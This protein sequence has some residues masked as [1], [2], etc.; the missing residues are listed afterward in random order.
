M[1]TTVDFMEYLSDQLG[2][3]TYRKMF[4]EYGIYRD[5]KLFA[6][7]CDNQLFVK[8]TEGGRPFG[9]SEA[10]PYEGAKP[11]FL[12]DDLEDRD[13]L[14]ALVKITC[15]ELPKPKKK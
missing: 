11:Y 9:L 5:G 14:A 2:E 15:A 6:L 4:G 10:P 7:A 12:V 3:I 8:I 1:A 13:R